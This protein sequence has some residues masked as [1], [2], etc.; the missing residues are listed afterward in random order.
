M[1][2]NRKIDL[3]A[4]RLSG[5]AGLA[6]K[7]R[8]YGAARLGI[9]SDAQPSVADRQPNAPPRT[10]RLPESIGNFAQ[11]HRRLLIGVFAGAAILTL[12]ALSWN[13]LKDDPATPQNA[14]AAALPTAVA[15]IPTP[16]PA[17]TIQ[18]NQAD[19]PIVAE[20][21]S[22]SIRQAGLAALK[23]KS[24]KQQAQPPEDQP[25]PAAAP[26]EQEAA[27]P[28][29]HETI[30]P[31]VAYGP[32]MSSTANPPVAA[33]NQGLSA[34]AALASKPASQPRYRA[35][36][37]GLSLSAVVRQQGGGLANINGRFVSVGDEVNGATVIAIA[38]MSVE[39]ELNGERFTVPY[40]PGPAQSE[41]REESRD[42]AKSAVAKE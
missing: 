8:N 5:T 2:D 11:T 35:C 19:A 21:Q 28:I 14:T 42:D 16:I 20:E 32:S 36:P 17:P 10:T 23:Q 39:M 31:R 3:V 1:S 18:Q 6:G 7:A 26:I 15:A 29:K 9:T 40:S 12:A 25:V 37:T 13:G 24:P 33:A 41:P 27:P 30:A 34:R 22:Q 38:D 4:G